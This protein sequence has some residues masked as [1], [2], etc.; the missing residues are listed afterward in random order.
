YLRSA[1]PFVRI[2]PGTATA[3]TAVI[4]SPAV[5]DVGTFSVTLGVT[6]GTV[7]DEA[8][9]TL[10]VVASGTPPD[11][12]PGP[13]GNRPPVAVIQAASVGIAGRPVPLN[14]ALSSDPDGDALTLSWSFGDGGAV[15]S[16]QRVEHRYAVE[17]SYQVDL[18]V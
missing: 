11:D 14:G 17:G 6:N 2:Q 12:P 1:P 4:F 5:G 10:E 8:S 18:T 3:P 16:G 15:A 9:F 13:S 7:R